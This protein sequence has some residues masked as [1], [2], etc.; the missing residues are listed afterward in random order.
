MRRAVPISVV[1]GIVVVL[2]YFLDK[3][4]LIHILN[5]LVNAGGWIL[6]QLKAL[7]DDL[8]HLVKQGS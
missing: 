7:I 2:L 1:I 8:T 3:A 6:N 4:L 5:G